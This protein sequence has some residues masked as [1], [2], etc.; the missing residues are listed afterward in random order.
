MKKRVG[1]GVKLVDVE[2]LTPA[3][4]NPRISDP[5]RLN[6][7]ELSLRKL[8][9]LL[10]IY[11]DAEGG[12]LSGHQRHLVAARMGCKQVPVKVVDL[13]Y[14]RTAKA[15]NIAFNRGTNDMGISDTT[16]SLIGALE[17]FDISGLAERL[18]DLQPDTPGFFPVLRARPFPTTALLTANAERMNPYTTSMARRLAQEGARMPI[19][20]RRSDLQ[21]VNGVGRVAYSQERDEETVPV[22]L[23]GDDQAALAHAMLNF[24]TMDFNIHERYADLLRYNSFRRAKGIRK[25]LGRAYTFLVLGMHKTA[26]HFDTSDPES[27]VK[28]TAAYGTRILDFGAG[29]GEQADLV[30]ERGVEVTTFEPYRIVTGDVIGRELSVEGVRRMLE[31]V[32]RGV[33]WD[34]VLSSAVFNSIPF[35][36]DREHVIRIMAA[37]CYP[38]GQLVLQTYTPQRS[39]HTLVAGARSAEGSRS[40]TH[41][42]FLAD[43]EPNAQISVDAGQRPKIQKFYTEAEMRALVSVGFREVQVV[44]AA[45]NI[46]AVGRHPK[47]IDVEALGAALDFE[48]DLP[49]PDGGRMGL[50]AE[51]RAA[52]AERLGVPKL[53]P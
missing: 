30:R 9:F 29:H 23:L 40:N 31:D 17:R 43:H 13:R 18:P 1:L 6:L 48:F 36:A 32:R 50:S 41:S 44:E 46:F 5:A 11:C 10:P 37:C 14:E 38:S 51:A 47:E 39:D 52:F 33:E 7:I 28:W 24:L 26:R 22:V 20:V 42:V 53:N 21:V 3:A 49:Y 12:I 16:S 45:D 8:G 34:T 25:H 15:I 19:V 4:Y 2:S 27:W 35:Q